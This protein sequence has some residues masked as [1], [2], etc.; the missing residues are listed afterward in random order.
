MVIK[1]DKQGIVRLSKSRTKK[2]GKKSIHDIINNTEC[3]SFSE[4]INYI[5]H[6]Y[7]YYEGAYEM[8]H[9]DKG[10]PNKNKEVLNNLIVKVLTK[11]LQPSVLKKYNTKILK[12][13]KE[14]Q[15]INTKI[16]I[17]NP[18]YNPEIKVLWKKDR[19]E[20]RA[21][22]FQEA[23]ISLIE[24]YILDS[25]ND[26]TFENTQYESYKTMKVKMQNWLALKDEFALKNLFTKLNLDDD[27]KKCLS[28]PI[29]DEQKRAEQK[30]RQYAMDLGY[31]KE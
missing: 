26:L 22:K 7:T 10:K 12:W 23:Y 1:A 18:K 13:K 20:K 15:N 3:L 21:N 6:H 4:K 25:S 9:D 8:F 24:E 11:K 31:I 17:D 30:M 28:T 14:H 5:R 29:N 19:Y 2:I 16:N 27:I